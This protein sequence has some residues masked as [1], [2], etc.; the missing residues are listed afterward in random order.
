M[1]RQPQVL[2]GAGHGAKVHIWKGA[3]AQDVTLAPV[4]QSDREQLSALQDAL[5]LQPSHLLRTLT[6]SLGSGL[7][8]PLDHGVNGMA[9]RQIKDANEAPGLHVAHTRRLDGG[10]QQSA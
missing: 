1:C 5:Q 10:L 8:L 9:Q 4:H 6:A 3:P 7:L 2:D